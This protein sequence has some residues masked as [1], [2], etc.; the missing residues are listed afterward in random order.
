MTQPAEIPLHIMQLSL[1]QDQNLEVQLYSIADDSLLKT[2]LAL[3]G[4]AALNLFHFNLPRLSVDADLNYIGDV[5]RETMI[6]ERTE[7]ETRIHQ[8]LQNLGLTLFRNP[9]AHAGGK[10]VWRYPSALGNQGNIEI[11][12]NFMYRIPLLPLE[13]RDSIT[14]ANQQVSQMQILDIH[15]IAAGKFS[16]LID[17][18]AGRDF[19]DAYNLFKHEKLS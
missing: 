3:K 10:M 19:F 15:E 11:D 7:I 8:L 12:L 6:Q 17:R 18:S 9:K 5:D 13:K 4:G 2:K 1:N 14:L 16:A